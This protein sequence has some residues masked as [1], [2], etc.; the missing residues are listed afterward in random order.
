MRGDKK[1]ILQKIKNFQILSLHFVN[2]QKG[3]IKV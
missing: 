2:A 1:C 3:K